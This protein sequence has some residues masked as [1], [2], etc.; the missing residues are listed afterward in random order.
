MI[1]T[2]GSPQAVVD[3]SERPWAHQKWW[4]DRAD[5]YAVPAWLMSGRTAKLNRGPRL[6]WPRVGACRSLGGCVTSTACSGPPVRPAEHAGRGSAPRSLAHSG[7]VPDQCRE[8]TTSVPA[9]PLLLYCLQDSVAR[10]APSA[11]SSP[12]AGSR[13]PCTRPAL[14]GGVRTGGDGRESDRW[15]VG[16]GPGAI[17]FS[18]D[19]VCRYRLTISAAAVSGS[20]FAASAMPARYSS[21]LMSGGVRFRS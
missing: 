21:V 8:L 16:G 9:A 5:A 7:C 10:L 6:S 15:Q 20:M 19:C 4:P 3:R 12:M 13:A 17:D 11:S 14:S 2:V 18:L 1:R